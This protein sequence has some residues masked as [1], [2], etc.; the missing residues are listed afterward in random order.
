MKDSQ[1]KNRA[2]VQ[3]I[4][5]LRMS[6]Q[7]L[8]DRIYE[9][10]KLVDSKTHGDVLS[11]IYQIESSKQSLEELKRSYQ[12]DINDIKGKIEKLREKIG[13]EWL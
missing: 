11:K 7:E 5:Q 3:Q 10:R 9:V 4:Q 12:K 2:Q 6:V 8:E 1:L 13:N